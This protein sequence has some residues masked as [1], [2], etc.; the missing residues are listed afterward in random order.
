M[1]FHQSTTKTLGK[2]DICRLAQPHCDNEMEGNYH[3]GRMYGAWKSID[4]LVKHGLVSRP[5]RRATYVH[6]RG[7]RS[8]PESFT[9]TRDGEMFIDAMLAKFNLASERAVSSNESFQSPEIFSGLE[10][11]KVSPSPFGKGGTGIRKRGVS[12]LTQRDEGELREWV[13]NAQ[14]SEQRSFDVGKDRR[15]NLHDACDA[16]MRENPGLV[17]LHTSN[18]VGRGRALVVTLVTRPSNPVRT[19]RE[20]AIV[21]LSSPDPIANPT[22]KNHRFKGVGRT[23]AASQSPA[24][25]QRAV[26]ASQAAAAA[27]LHRQAIHQSIMEQRGES[28][29][30][31]LRLEEQVVEVLS[32]DEDF[33]VSSVPQF[34]KV[35]DRKQGKAPPTNESAP[36]CLDLDDDGEDSTP[37]TPPPSA[38]AGQRAVTGRTPQNKQCSTPMQP[39]VLDLDFEGEP[40]P[41]SQSPRKNLRDSSHVYDLETDEESIIEIEDSQDCSAIPN[42]DPGLVANEAHSGYE[43]LQIQID[44]RERNRNQTPRHLRLE[45]SR[46]LKSGALKAVWPAQMPLATAEEATLKCGDFAFHLGEGDQKIAL[47]VAVERKRIADL[48]QR[49]TTGDHW[50]QLCKMR[51]NYRHVVMVIEVDSREAARSVAFG[52]QS[53]EEWNPYDTTIEDESSVFLF[54]GHAILSHPSVNFIQSRDEQGSLRGIGALGLMASAM[55]TPRLPNLTGSSTNEQQRLSDKLTTAGIPW[56]LVKIVA[57]EFGSVKSLETAYNSCSSERC[58]SALLVPILSWCNTKGCNGTAESWSN[59]INRAMRTVH[60]TPVPVRKAIEEYKHLVSDQGVLVG[61]LHANLDANV[62]LDEALSFAT[63]KSPPRTIRKV[64]VRVES[65]HRSLLP[66]EKEGSFLEIDLMDEGFFGST[67]PTMELQTSQG[68]LTSDRLLIHVVNARSILATVGSSMAKNGTDFLRAA[69]EAAMNTLKDCGAQGRI[70]GSVRQVLIVRGLPPAVD[71]FAKRPGYRMETRV[72]V[73][74]VFASLMLEHSVVILQALRLKDEV[75][76]ILQQIALACYH[77]QILKKEL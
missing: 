74:L 30:R 65:V 73:D 56:E 57:R 38:L 60:K 18:G 37:V 39:I 45:L 7:F 75:E 67:V 14:P 76:L 20:G 4:T 58:K 44:S 48:V 22:K 29:R 66:D 55:E 70:G 10:L 25:R 71:S 52:S 69:Q 3:A 47:N 8:A 63:R 12:H 34:R 2:K 27:A 59:A 49:S 26:P 1:A 54:M 40:A 17:L 68:D 5:G 21:G 46:L 31:K 43:P 36:I 11:A 19:I 42:S 13:K 50:K 24:K 33:K 72:V 35:S 41:V 62:A 16:L 6:G 15:K 61:A 64:S 28:A 51:D 23:L 32:D 77:Y 53:S 9:L